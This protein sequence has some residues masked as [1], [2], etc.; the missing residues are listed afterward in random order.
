M[1]SIS[2]TS[3]SASIITPLNSNISTNSA[4]ITYS[5]S[6]TWI[7]KSNNE[8]PSS[9]IGT[10]YTHDYNY[11]NI[12][13]SWSFSTSQSASSANGSI[14]LTPLSS[15]EVNTITATVT[16]EG[17]EQVLYWEVVT[18]WDPSE[19]QQSNYQTIEEFQF[20]YEQW[21]AVRVKRYSW[22][23][24]SSW[25][26]PYSASQTITITAYTRPGDFSD[27]NFSANTIIQS[28][29]GLTAAK[30]DN[31][32]DHCNALA[33]WYNQNT[34][35]VAEGCRVSSGDLITAVW[36]NACIDA[37]PTLTSQEKN[38]YHV[39]GGA[40]GTIITAARINLLG[41]LIS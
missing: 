19:P 26:N 35:D 17:T 28:S 11:S 31:W 10:S 37:I 22:D 40:N 13:Y 6:A 27:Y 41:T 32:C 8:S 12:S 33:H 7:N 36:Y 20:D 21:L 9:S 16:A 15:G 5:C 23:L 2:I 4:N 39:T 24:L 34:T 14:T 3:A 25:S 1:A 38:N 18:Y 30:V 29:D